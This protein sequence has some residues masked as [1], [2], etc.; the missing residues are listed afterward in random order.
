MLGRPPLPNKFRIPTT[1]AK[2]KAAKTL[3]ATPLP[4]VAVKAK[5]ELVKRM[6]ELTE[7]VQALEVLSPEQYQEADEILGMIQT[8]R[9]DWQV[10]FYGGE[11]QGKTYDPIIPPMRAS[12]DALY[13]LVREIDKPLEHL[14][15]KVKGH[16]VA[17]KTEELRQ[18]RELQAAQEKER[19][20][21]EREK[22][23]LLDQ[24]EQARTPKQKASIA[25]QLE[26]LESEAEAVEEQIIP[27]S[28]ANSS[29]RAPRSWRH[30]DMKLTLAAIKAG[31]IPIDVV[32]INNL[33]VNAYY[34]ADAET[35]ETWPGFEGFED[36][37][38]VGRRGR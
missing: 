22:Q 10:R 16:M 14:E 33:T 19:Q 36:V 15:T 38:I 31:L 37:T 24:Q 25:A 28:G 35:V 32:Q 21:L 27:V 30:L 29:S 2:I 26:S 11:A 12:L 34:K 8:A 13:A 7:T 17:Y 3:A 6:P 9:K 20:R 5:A 1:P 18:Q 4:S 23:E